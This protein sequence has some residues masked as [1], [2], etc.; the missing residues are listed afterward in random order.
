MTP[1]SDSSDDNTYGRTLNT[2]DASPRLF[3]CHHVYLEVDVT[4]EDG[5]PLTEEDLLAFLTPVEPHPVTQDT[6]SNSYCHKQ[7]K[8]MVRSQYPLLLQ[9]ISAILYD[10]DPICLNFE[11]ND[12]EY[13][14][15]AISII[16]ELQNAKSAKDV[17]SIV[18]R[19]FQEWLCYDLSPYKD[20]P[21]F[22]RMCQGIWMAW[23]AHEKP[24]IL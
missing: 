16:Y 22:I 7:F 5:R 10:C 13:D 11:G 15:E 8:A 23:C 14:P 1:Q 24:Q 9:S 19:Q 20:N 2:D 18:I 6:N 4:E 17:S 21:K 3:D 12:D